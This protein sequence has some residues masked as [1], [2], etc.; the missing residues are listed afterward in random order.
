MAFDGRRLAGAVGPEDPEDLAA[1]HRER[2]VIDR[3]HVAVAHPQVLDRHNIRR[4]SVAGGVVSVVVHT[5]RIANIAA[6]HIG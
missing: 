1:A 3:D 2:D 6:E 4:P 5:D